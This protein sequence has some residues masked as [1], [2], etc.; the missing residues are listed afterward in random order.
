MS[1]FNNEKIIK[2]IIFAK[3]NKNNSNNFLDKS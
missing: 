1:I 3:K 2:D